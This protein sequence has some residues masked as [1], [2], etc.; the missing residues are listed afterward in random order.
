MEVKWSLTS[1][2]PELEGHLEQ[3]TIPEFDGTRSVVE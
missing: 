3:E 2:S 1:I